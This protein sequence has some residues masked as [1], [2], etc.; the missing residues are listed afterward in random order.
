[1]L[2]HLVVARAAAVLG[3]EQLADAREVDDQRVGHARLQQPAE[4]IATGTVEDG[5]A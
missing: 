3:D 2:R 5:G 4:G 1:M